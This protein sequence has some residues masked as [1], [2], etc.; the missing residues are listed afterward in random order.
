MTQNRLIPM[1]IPLLAC[2]I[3]ALALPVHADDDHRGRDNGRHI[4]RD[5]PP[6]LARKDPPC[7]PPGLARQGRED[8]DDRPFYLTGDYLILENPG[9][10]GLDPDLT[11]GSA[12][13][14]IYRI[15]R[16]TREVLALIGAIED[17][18][19]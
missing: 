3:A 5:C 19:N 8:D 14:M 4:G 15:D 11:Y 2:A 13:G 16:D 9:R 12:G 7:V 17:V 18:L 6:G 10:F 1:R